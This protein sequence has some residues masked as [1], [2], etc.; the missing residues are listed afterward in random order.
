[1]RKLFSITAFALLVLSVQSAKAQNPTLPDQA[2]GRAGSAIERALDSRAGLLE[3]ANA[4]ARGQ[5]EI[6]A[7]VTARSG[8]ET[9]ANANAQINAGIDTTLRGNSGNAGRPALPPVGARRLLRPEFDADRPRSINARNRIGL[10]L[11]GRMNPE[12]TETRKPDRAPN[13]RRPEIQQIRGEVRANTE[14]SA[15]QRLF[16]RRLAQIDQMRDIALANG[17]ERQLEQA[18][19][20]EQLARWQMENQGSARSANHVGVIIDPE[21]GEERETTRHPFRS[22]RIAAPIA[23]GELET[24][25]QVETNVETNVDANQG[26]NLETNVDANVETNVETTTNVNP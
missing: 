18:D 9:R 17:N 2:R 5:A 10:E 4:Q 16:V 13:P 7:D 26:V 8:L 12:E 15:A 3:R 21:T 19:H 25:T 23:D 14:L 6:R 11:R 22:G 24:E 1:M 20:L